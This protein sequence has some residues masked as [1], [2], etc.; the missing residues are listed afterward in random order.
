MMYV[1]V[2]LPGLKGGP[3]EN[4]TMEI[5]R[6]KGGTE[7]FNV[8]TYRVWCENESADFTH[9]YGDGWKR[10]IVRALEALR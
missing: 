4:K 7:D 10:C 6:L 3:P 1:T 9:M 5:V 8:N 2:L